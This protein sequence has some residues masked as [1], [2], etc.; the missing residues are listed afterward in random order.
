MKTII[1]TIALCVIVISGFTQNGTSKTTSS[2]SAI[3]INVPN[4]A[5]PATKQFYEAYTS[6]IKKAVTAIRNKDEAAFMKLTEEGKTLEKKFEYYMS[7]KKSTPEDI[8]KK[9]TWNKQAMPY[10][11]EIIQ[12]DFNKKLEKN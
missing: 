10:I 12:S 7:E 6:H 9:H 11:Q 1:L 8:T 3:T 5:D 4:F 2:P